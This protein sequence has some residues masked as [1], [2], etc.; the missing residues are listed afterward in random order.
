MKKKIETETYD[1]GYLRSPNAKHHTKA[2]THRK[3]DKV[4]ELE[5]RVAGCERQVEPS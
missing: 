1:K 2:E 3:A 4:S 5:Q